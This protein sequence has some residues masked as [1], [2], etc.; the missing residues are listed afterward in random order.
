MNIKELKITSRINVEKFEEFILNLSK[1]SQ[2][3]FNHFGTI[4]KKTIRK[5]VQNEL[6]R[7]DK[8][9]FFALMNEQLVGYSF[10]ITFS[11]PTKKYNCTLGI[12]IS[13]QFQNFGIGKKMCNYMIKKAWKRK[14]TKIWLNVFFD[15]KI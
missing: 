13:D 3:E 15:N 6:K 11:K 4:N 12:I 2:L 9:R 7:K 1:S 14:F 10:L 5:I 8:M